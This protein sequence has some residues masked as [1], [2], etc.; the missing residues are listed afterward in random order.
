VDTLERLSHDFMEAHP[1]SSA[2]VLER[3]PLASLT[4][5]FGASPPRAAAH[6]LERLAPDMAA[7]CL[8]GIQ[9]PAAAAIIAELSFGFRVLTLRHMAA[10]SREHV[11]G[12]LAGELAE[13]LRRVLRHPP[14]TVGELADPYVLTVPEDVTAGEALRRARRAARGVPYHVFV[15]DRAYRLAGAVSLHA[16]LRAPGKEA[17]R[18]VM[19]ARVSALAVDSTLEEAVLDPL[20]REWSTAPVIDRDGLFLGA[21]HYERILRARRETLEPG[22]AGSGLDTVLAFGELYW[23]GLFGVLEGVSGAGRGPGRGPAPDGKGR[24]GG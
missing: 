23:Q 9:P 1:V 17:L 3:L 6:T 11:L 20:W 24:D 7:A 8:G 19:Y 18:S 22:R 14:G 12:A 15:V 10:A 4:A 5:L 13:A 16:L 21:V 2:R